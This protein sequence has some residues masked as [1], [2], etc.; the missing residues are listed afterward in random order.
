MKNQISG[1]HAESSRS[2]DSQ[3]HTIT[4][5]AESQQQ[6]IPRGKIKLVAND[7][8]KLRAVNNLSVTKNKPQERTTANQYSVS[9]TLQSQIA[10]LQA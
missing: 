4:S 6:V 7:G 1:Q 3:R 10:Q 9:K 2:K 5:K 8:S